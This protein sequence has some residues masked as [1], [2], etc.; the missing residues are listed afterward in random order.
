MPVVDLLL[1]EF[2]NRFGLGFHFLLRFGGEDSSAGVSGGRRCTFLPIERGPPLRL[3]VKRAWSMASVRLISL[4]WMNIGSRFEEIVAR[5]L[6]VAEGALRT[7][8]AVKMYDK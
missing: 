3:L 8:R 4:H 1:A 2:G 5:R 6:G 7:A